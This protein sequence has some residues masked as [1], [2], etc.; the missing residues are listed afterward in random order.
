M[1]SSHATTSENSNGIWIGIDLGTSNS[2]VAIW[3]SSRGSSKWIRLP[4]ISLKEI[5]GKHGRMVPSVVRIHG[6][7]RF[8]VGAQAIHQ[9][10]AVGDDSKATPNNADGTLV[11][12]I[13]RLFGKRY[14]DLDSRLL[15]SLPFHVEEDANEKGAMQLVVPVTT[16][17]NNSVLVVKTDPVEIA[18]ILLREIRQASQ[19]YL[20][21][22][23]KRKHLQV[24]G[25]GR[26]RHVIVGV[27]AHFSKRQIELLESA[28]RQAGFDGHVGT[29]LESTAAAMAYGLSM[30]ES[31]KTANIM[32]ID[33]GGGT[34]DITIA[35]KLQK[36]NQET[37]EGNFSSYKVL[38]TQG[39]ENLGGDDIDQALMEYCSQQ[40]SNND[41][42]DQS[43]WKVACRQAKEALCNLDS[44]SSSETISV[45]EHN[46]I[47]SQEQF[48]LLLKSWLEKAKNLIETTRNDFRRLEKGEISEVILVGGT[49]K[50]PAIRGMIQTLFPSLELC[51]SLNPMSSVAQGLAIQA[52]IQSKLV[53]LHQLKSALMLDCVP[54]A[55]GVELSNGNFCQ[56]IPRNAPLP[57]RGF[58]T[59]ELADK[60]QQGVTIRAV[61][62][63][64][65]DGC[66]FEPM[67][68]ED[69]TFLLRRLPQDIL[70][71]LSC[72]TIQLGM[73]VDNEGQFTVS[74]FDENDPEQVRKRE[75]Y[76]K[77]SAS[78]S[79][80]GDGGGGGD[81]GG[82]DGGDIDTI[83]GELGYITELILS[84]SRSSTEQ[85]LLFG[86]LIGVFV[87]Y[88]AVK[89]AFNDPEQGEGKGDGIF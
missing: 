55:I 50:T 42:F 74:V 76:E 45:G 31:S 77:I 6:D 85:L 86:M 40:A 89:L 18:S 26:I 81:N 48:K 72:R 19:Q 38:V 59:F 39:D 66:K 75:R 27:P 41:T 62:Q 44:P 14:Q 32:V 49:T 83:V 36:N 73:K 2:A 28:C 4:K 20:D 71:T 25:E 63:I 30:Q 84:E 7:D 17:D 37:E 64:D 61:E 9:Q 80:N 52:A 65:D 13:K 46:I 58:A 8:S 54:H 15:D 29:C 47:V 35:T 1:N 10:Q 78:S 57:A 16:S 87:L 5:S 79:S 51:T 82:G 12:S 21:K 24:P 3:D 56:L 23:Q 88:I 69:F 60:K 34:T 33:M 53:P 43:Q 70:D 22:Y 11:S 68:T 67:S